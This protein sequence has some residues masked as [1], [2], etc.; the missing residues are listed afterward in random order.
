MKVIVQ[1]MNQCFM[2]ILFN[3]VQAIQDARRE[4]I[5]GTG[6]GRIIISASRIGSSVEIVISDN[7]IGIKEEILTKI[8]DPF[9]TTKPVGRGQGLGLTESFAVIKKHRGEI[10]V[11]SRHK[12]GTVVKITLPVQ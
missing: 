3:S 11:E 1:E 8:F 9:F 6:A 7:G 12:E 10:K 5:I 4:K 2:N